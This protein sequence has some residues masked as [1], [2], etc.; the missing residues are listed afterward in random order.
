MAT[1]DFRA[2]AERHYK[3]G[4]LLS[5]QGRLRGA[6]HFFGIAAECALKATLEAACVLKLDARGMPNKPFDQHCPGIWNEYA[7]AHGG[8]ASL[9]RLP[10]PQDNPFA[11]T[12]HITDRYAGD[13]VVD[14]NALDAHRFGALETLKIMQSFSTGEAN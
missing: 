4:L 3:D 1:P 6:D 9:R 8:H 2:A 14:S 12:W 10:L 13:G 5:D 11:G 7:I